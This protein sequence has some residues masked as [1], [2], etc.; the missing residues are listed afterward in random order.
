MCV[1]CVCLCVSIPLCVRACQDHI[2]CRTFRCNQCWVRSHEI[3]SWLLLR[4]VVKMLAFL[5]RRG[6]WVDWWCWSVYQS[7]NSIECRTTHFATAFS[8][9]HLV[10]LKC[11]EENSKILL[12]GQLSWCWSLTGSRCYNNVYKCLPVH[13][14]FLF[15]TGS[16]LATFIMGIWLVAGGLRYSILQIGFS[17]L[18]LWRKK[19]Y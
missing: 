19:R 2:D 6:L 12:S 5:K 1:L 17:G 14:Q 4:I 7:I 8:S 16:N 13:A 3:T 11:P 15:W 10:K 9:I 18:W